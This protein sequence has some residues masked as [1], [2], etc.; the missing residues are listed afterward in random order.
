M[1]W[2]L[3]SVLLLI[4]LVQNGLAQAPRAESD[5]R[6]ATLPETVRAQ[7]LAL[8]KESDPVTR[9]ASARALARKSPFGAMDFLLSILE[10]EKASA[11][12]REIL[13]ELGK[14]NDPRV[15][16]ALE[17]H[18]AADPDPALAILAA[19]RLTALRHLETLRL[20]EQRMKLAGENGKPEERRRLALE[21]E[22]WLTLRLGAALPGFLR[23]PPPVF[24][25]KPAGQA[26]RVL[27][28]G[29]YGQGNVYQQEAAA[30]MLKYHR[31]HPF[32]FAIT[33]GDNFYSRG[34]ES[35]SDPR[36][37]TWWDEL[38]DPLGVPFFASLGNHDWGLPDSPAAEVLYTQKSPSWRMPATR[39]TFTAG[40][41]QF[42]ALD[43]QAMSP[44][45]LMW[46]DEELQK[47]KSRWRIAYG[48]HPIYS[49]GQH[50]DTEQLI[51]DLL[52]VL[53][54]RVDAFFC[55]HEH[56]LQHLKPEGGVHFFISGGGGA[57]I[58][59]IE[60]GQRSLF[61]RSS[62]GFAVLEADAKAL[63]VKFIDQNV[64]QLYEYTLTK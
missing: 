53:Q 36:W 38:Y 11:V 64:N 16:R 9:A 63:T 22:R 7:G 57:R 23:T 59:P 13:T 18:A 4:L 24:S 45:Q 21:H 40:P 29:D 62:Y 27:A 17:K 14:H 44:A 61:A 51:R 56:D 1:L 43:T 5:P 48:H 2:W 47:S 8:L 12:R 15:F 28:F 3:R 39:Y 6:L 49:H 33:L 31:Q 41:V 60:P 10:Q 19:E 26:I 34:M 30:A 42:F 46:L 35:P 54:G 20:M 37:K 52:P 32:D 25:V 55:G 58:R 50:G